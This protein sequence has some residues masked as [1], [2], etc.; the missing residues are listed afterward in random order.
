MNMPACPTCDAQIGA[1]QKFCGECGSALAAGC[2]ACGA[3]N[4]PGHKFCGECGGPLGAGAPTAENVPE[5]PQPLAPIAERRLVSVLFADLVGFTTLSEGR[6]A[7]AVRELLSRYFETCQRVIARYGGTVEKFIG[8]AVMAVWGSPVAQED[9]SER[10]VRAALE[11]VAAVAALGA[12]VGADDLRARAGVLTGEAAVT[13]GATSEGMVA[14]DLVNTASR[15]QSAA[16]PGTVLV[17]ESTKLAT[18]AAIAYA[19]ATLHELKGKAEPVALY[20][21]LRVTAGRAGARRWHGL[22]VPFVGRD[23][24]LH[25]I[26]ELFHASAEEQRAHLVSVVGAAGVGKSRL[27]WEFEKYIDGLAED[28]LWHHGRCLA[29]GEGVGYWAIAEMVRMRCGIAE[30]NDTA[31][32]RSKLQLTL[33]EFI[34]DA[35][36]RQWVEPRLSHLLALEDSAVDDH[37]NLFPAWRTFFERV[38]DQA[39]AVL[40][41]EDMQWAQAGLLGFIDHL[42]EWSRNLRLYIVVLSRPESVHEQASL[43]A[44]KRNFSALYLEALAPAAMTELLTGLVPGLPDELQVRILAHAE[45]IPLYAVETVRM[46]LDR[47]MLEQDGEVYRPTGAVPT[48]EVP[49]TLHALIAARLDGLDPD[50]RLLLQEASVLGKVF[51]KQGLAA[52]ASVPDV[53]GLLGTLVR[54][55]LLA[56]QADPR[57]PERGQYCFLQDLVRRVAYDTIAKRDR[58]ARHLAAAEYLLSTSGAEEGETV[59]VVASHY[60]AAYEAAAGDPDVESIGL[61]ARETLVRAAERAASLGANAEAQRAFE[62]ALEL[63]GEPLEQGALHERAGMMAA[64]G[65]RAD[66]ASEHF[67]QSITLFEQASEVRPAARVAARLAEIQWERGRLE[68]GLESMERSLDVLLQETPDEAV[69]SLAAQVGRFRFFSGDIDIATD[70]IETALTL[71]EALALPEV[72]SQALNTKAIVLAAKGRRDESGVLLRRAL[73]IALQHDKQSAALRAFYNLADAVLT[74]GDEYASAADSVRQGLVHARKF[75]SRYWEWAFLGFGSPFYALGEWD[76][77]L[78][79][80]DELPQDDWTGGRIAHVTLLTSAVPVCIHRGQID[81]AR[82]MVEAVAKVEQSADVQERCQYGYAR[83]LLH[84]AAGDHEQALATAESVFDARDTLPI[85][86]DAI[87]E[88][89]MVAVQSSLELGRLDRT[90]ELIT[91]VEQLLPGQRPRFLDAQVARFR[92]LLTARQTTGDEPER[93]FAR[94]SAELQA[95]SMPF[96]LAVVQVEHAEWLRGE[97][98][99]AEAQALSTV[100]TETFER[101]GAKPWLDRVAGHVVALSTDSPR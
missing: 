35:K 90:E 61:H 78:A 44:G 18:E 99:G 22:E 82:A 68:Q 58:K 34:L 24:E 37:E 86:G 80:R 51:T 6:D 53:E 42:L 20:R 48:L 100:A 25:L 49:Q 96:H 65:A 83:A 56:I 55:E 94:A 59:E 33:D 47:G 26:K 70:R 5:T 92:A 62:R 54:K 4:P 38:A 19:E 101:L 73:E 60:L 39:P 32:A 97:N 46:L 66:Q 81:E 40:V 52:T 89:F 88:S 2:Q 72:L 43:G 30:D 17:G 16:E 41:F 23:R 11:L 93:Y 64:T 84:S 79:M 77:V 76:E 71:A 1:D 9:D 50:E 15:I 31:T 91:T 74:M 57:S 3:N 45:G 28:V 95:L 7:E 87:K 21:A 98:R 75:G 69:A 67:Q 63:T 14:G 13:I 85:G 27:S 12:E 29:Y 8:D 10:A 36:E